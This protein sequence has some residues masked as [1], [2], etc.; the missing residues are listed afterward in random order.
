[1]PVLV[2]DPKP[3]PVWIV[4]HVV[5]VLEAKRLYHIKYLMAISQEWQG[6]VLKYMFWLASKTALL[7]RTMKLRNNMVE[8]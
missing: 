6:F 5:L 2:P 3:T 4:F 7:S 1:M 8:T